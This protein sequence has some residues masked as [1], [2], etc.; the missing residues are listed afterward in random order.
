MLK[1]LIKKKQSGN[2]DMIACFFIILGLSAI[3]LLCVNFIGDMF[4]IIRVDQIARQG[5]LLVETEGK[6]TA[7]DAETIKQLLIDAG[8]QEDS[9]EIE[10]LDKNKNKIEGTKTVGYGNMITLH[11]K[12]K[13][14]KTTFS[15]FTI[16]RDYSD[17][18]YIERYK[19]SIAKY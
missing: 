2:G 15:D 13:I 8:A 3:L 6:L 19:S 11:I 10:A 16:K 12:C 7:G 4:T 1:N 18:H 17:D 5:L 14:P 9:I